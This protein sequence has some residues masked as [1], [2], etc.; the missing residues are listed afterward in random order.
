MYYNQLWRKNNWFFFSK[1]IIM[2]AQMYNA[3]D[4]QTV[5]RISQEVLSLYGE[6]QLRE[7][8]EQTMSKN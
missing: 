7:E 6:E 8:R 1:I 5:I 4:D 2:N 3:T